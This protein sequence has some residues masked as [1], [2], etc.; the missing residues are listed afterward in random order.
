[1]TPEEEAEELVLTVHFYG[2]KSCG[3]LCKAA[4]KK[5]MPIAENRGLDIVAKLLRAAYV[6]DCN[7]S[8]QTKEE[9]QELK[10]NLPQFMKE[11]GFPIKAMACSGEEAHE[12]LSDQGMINT[13]G[14]SW[15]SREDTMKMIIPKLFIGEKK[16]V[17]I[18]TR[19]HIF[20]RRDIN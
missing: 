12:E 6:D 15:N 17:K 1:M 5:M 4:V 20:I 19:V 18:H 8:F 7:C 9:V 2:V 10:E 3:G 13:A 16:K 14:Y 11:H